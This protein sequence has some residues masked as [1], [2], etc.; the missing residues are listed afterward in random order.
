MFWAYLSVREPNTIH[1]RLMSGSTG[2]K[3]ATILIVLG[4][5]EG[6]IDLR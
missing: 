2:G 4:A 5:R 1:I 3:E 6:A